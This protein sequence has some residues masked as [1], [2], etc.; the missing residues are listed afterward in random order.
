VATVAQLAALEHEEFDELT[1]RA[2]SLNTRIAAQQQAGQ[3]PRADVAA[4]QQR[5]RNYLAQA[6]SA[7]QVADVQN[8][9]KYME[10]AEAELAKI[11]KII[12][13]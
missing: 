2:N 12:G 3:Q 6:Q 8:A 7:L 9:Q 10:Q 4:S 5:A 13:H 1:S 11:E